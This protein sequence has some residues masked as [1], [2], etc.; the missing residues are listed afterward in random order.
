MNRPGG[1]P[2]EPLT[3]RPIAPADDPAMAAIIREV[4]TDLGAGGPGF[5]I[6]DPEVA[7]MSQAYA[8]AGQAYY[9]VVDGDGQVVGGAGFGPLAGGDAGTCELRKMYF[10][11]RA[12]GRGMGRRMLTHVLDRARAAGYRRCYLETLVSMEAARRL[13]E[14]FGFERIAAPL[15]AT[16]HY[17]CD[18]WYVRAL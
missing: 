8:A 12:R 18:A 2:A 13:Y 6:H 1:P 17:T 14:A 4:M 5:A 3:L 9:V 16:G 11:P 7:A 10:L 15:G